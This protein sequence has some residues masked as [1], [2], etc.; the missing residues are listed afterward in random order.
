M[1]IDVRGDEH[2]KINCRK[3]KGRHGVRRKESL[4]IHCV[5]CGLKQEV[6]KE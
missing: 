6:V 2:V 3:C 1:V 5:V 4:K